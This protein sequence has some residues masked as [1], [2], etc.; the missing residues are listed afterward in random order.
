VN[1]Q[2]VDPTTFDL[3]VGIAYGAV[4]E[5]GAAFVALVGAVWWRRQRVT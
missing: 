3:R 4:V 2:A 1:G 5:V